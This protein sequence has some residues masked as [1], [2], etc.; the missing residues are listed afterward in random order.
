MKKTIVVLSLI[1]LSAYIY[2][3]TG[4]CCH[5]C[6]CGLEYRYSDKTCEAIIGSSGHTAKV[7]H[8]GGLENRCVTCRDHGHN[9][10]PH[11]FVYAPEDCHSY[12]EE[13]GND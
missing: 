9:L 13:E 12:V 6:E 8:E 4:N 3:G 2:A 7:E 10:K 5:D 11:V 1:A